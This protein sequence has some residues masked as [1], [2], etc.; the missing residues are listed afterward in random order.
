MVGRGQDSSRSSTTH[1]STPVC[2]LLSGWELDLT[3][4][5]LL[6][7]HFHGPIYCDLQHAGHGGAAERLRTPRPLP[8][9]AAWCGLLR[10]ASA[11]RGRG[12]MSAH[13]SD[14]PLGHSAR[15]WRFV[16]RRH[17]RQKRRGTSCARLRSLDDLPPR[18][19]LATS[20]RGGTDGTAQR[21]PRSSRARPRGSPAAIRPGVA[22]C[23]GQRIFRGCS[24]VT[25]SSTPSVPLTGRARVTW[26]IA[27]R[28]A[29]PTTCVESSVSRD[30]RH[31]P[32]AFA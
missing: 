6:R 12:E 24:P 15:R 23:G 16:P 27:A 7:Q 17:T 29:S 5:Q 32:S 9:V 11:E 2:E 30:D 31:Q 21:G 4:T 8:D 14:G 18:G 13:R 20:P 22:T 25:G 19:G 10:R 28:R 3:T 26:S 1:D